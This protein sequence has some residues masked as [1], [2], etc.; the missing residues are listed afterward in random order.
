MYVTVHDTVQ[1]FNLIMFS[2]CDTHTVHM[3]KTDTQSESCIIMTNSETYI[4]HSIECFFFVGL[5]TI[6][7]RNEKS[8][9]LQSVLFPFSPQVICNLHFFFLLFLG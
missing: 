7:L 2:L 8:Q 6:E 1:F 9:C 4:V 5:Y 3:Y